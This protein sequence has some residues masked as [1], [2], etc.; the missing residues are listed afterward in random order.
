MVWHGIH[1]SAIA[2]QLPAIRGYLQEDVRLIDLQD[3]TY[4]MSPLIWS[5]VMGHDD[6]AAWLLA[7]GASVD[8]VD[9]GGRS[10]LFY[11]SKIGYLDLV[12]VLLKHNPDVRKQSTED[13]V[14]ALID[15]ACSLPPLSSKSNACF[16]SSHSSFAST[17]VTT[18]SRAA[19]SSLSSSSVQSPAIK[20]YLD[21]VTRRGNSAVHCAS[22]FP[23]ILK[24]LLQ[25]GAN[26]TLVNREGHTALEI[27]MAK[28]VPASV[29]V[30]K[31]YLQEKESRRARC[32]YK[33][34]AICDASHALRHT[35]VTS[36]TR[37]EKRRKCLSVTP[38]YLEERV[39]QEAPLPL[40]LVGSRGEDKK[41]ERENGRGRGLS[42]VVRA[43]RKRSFERQE[44][45]EEPV[46][47]LHAQTARCP[48]VQDPRTQVRE[49]VFW[50]AVG[51]GL[52]RELFVELMD[53]MLPKWDP[54]RV[55]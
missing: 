40:L 6:V 10:A 5:C 52:K 29:R 39:A 8:L 54:E 33:A 16:S 18:T 13:V 36:K 1:L 9:S 25:K 11:A 38:G 22:R 47:A 19:A 15:H 23:Q 44:E 51:G 2:K 42:Q 17:T 49:A 28:N 20:E 7:R 46:K 41:S 30:L 21:L 31:K 37:A 50:H 4:G 26:P 43:N 53:M 12:S 45:G 27:A 32:L 3:D 34:R 48:S 24:I 55:R 14:K 35:Y